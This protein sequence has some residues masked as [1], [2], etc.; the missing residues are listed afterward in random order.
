MFMEMSIMVGLLETDARDIP[1]DYE[2]FTGNSDY[3]EMKPCHIDL[4]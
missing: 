3:L 2:G 1:K 4:E